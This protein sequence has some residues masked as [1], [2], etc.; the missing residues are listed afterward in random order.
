MAARLLRLLEAAV[1]DPDRAIGSLDILAADERH[2]ILH[3]WNDTARAVPPATLPAAVRRAGRPHSRRDRGGVRGADAELRRARRARQSAGASPARSR[4]RPRDR[5]GALRRALARRCWSGCSASSRPVAPICRSTRATRPSASRSCSR[6]PHAP[7]L[8]TQSALLDRL[9]AHRRAA[10]C[11]S[12]PTGPA[13]A[14]RPATAPAVALDPRHP[15]YVIYTS[16][17]T[18]TPKGVAVD[19]REPGEQALDLGAQISVLDRALGSLLLTSCG[20]RCLDRAS[21]AGAAVTAARVVLSCRSTATPRI[22]A[23]SSGDHVS[24]MR[25]VQ[26]LDCTSIAAVRHRCDATSGCAAAVI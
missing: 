24:C 2:T 25:D 1:A 16:G 20:F 12:M 3:G 8:V 26:L 10:L 21:H 23:V 11:S 22:S 7:V 4:R 18:G 15:A 19:A 17:S 13:I 9:P 14:R 5:G 6:M